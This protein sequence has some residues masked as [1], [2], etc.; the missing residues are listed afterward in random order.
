MTGASGFIASHLVPALVADGWEVRTCGRRP[1]PSSLPAEAE[2]QALDLVESPLDGLVSGVTAV[3][4]LAGASSSRSS[5]EEMHR[6]NVVASERLFEALRRSGSLERALVMSSTSVYGEEKQ[7][8]SPVPE[9]VEPSPSR[10]YGKA[11]WEA[12]QVAWRASSDGMPVVV[13]RPVSVHGPGAIKLLASAILDVA[14]ER[15]LGLD[16]L[17]LHRE[18]VEQRMLHVDDLVGACLHLMASPE[19]PGR[20]F[21]VSSGQYPTSHEVAGVLADHF[22]MTVELDDDPD[23]GPPFEERRRAHSAMVARGMD[24]SILLTPERLRFMRKTNRNNRLSLKALEETGF[25][26]RHTDLRQVVVDDVKWYRQHRWILDH[27]A[28]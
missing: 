24:D 28:N 14:I 17:A 1:R 4:H 21:N 2:Y 3:F 18:P 15:F 27:Q 11:K 23:C 9:D 26:P 16:R 5:E 22:G 13:V 19:A 10:G 7:L 8:P 12:E 6:D 25:R 20:A